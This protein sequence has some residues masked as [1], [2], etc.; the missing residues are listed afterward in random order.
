MRPYLEILQRSVLLRSRALRGVLFLASFAAF[1]VAVYAQA[2][3]LGNLGAAF[4]VAFGIAGTAGW[5]RG[6]RASR[7]GAPDRSV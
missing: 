4:G 1:M 3:W 2:A 5:W 7:D 6:R